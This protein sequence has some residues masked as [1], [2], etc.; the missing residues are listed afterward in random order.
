MRRRLCLCG[1]ALVLALPVPAVAQKSLPPSTPAAVENAATAGCT[2]GAFDAT[3]RPG[4]VQA[5]LYNFG[6]LFW[7]GGASTYEVPYHPA[8]GGP[9]THPLFAMGLWVSGEVGGDLR[10]AGATYSNWEFW[11]GPLD[12]NGATTSNRCSAFDRLWRVSVYDLERYTTS[13]ET[14]A[15]TQDL[16]TWPIAQGAPYFLDTNGNDRRDPSEPRLTLGP[17]D[18]GYSLNRN[19]GAVLD[20]AAGYRPDL[21][22]DEAVWWV[23]ND[24]GNVHRWSGSAPLGVEVQVLAYGYYGGISDPSDRA[25][26]LA[27]FYEYTV[28]NRGSSPIDDARVSFFVDV[29]L[30][31]YEDDQIASDPGRGMLYGY[32]GDA[33]DARSNPTYG[34]PLGYGYRVPAVGVDLLSGAA[35]AIEYRTDIAPEVPRGAGALAA[36]QNRWADG[37][38]ITRGGDGHG[39]PSGDATAWIF[40]GDP[41]TFAYWSPERPEVDGFGPLPPREV[42]GVINA[43]AATLA[44]G[45]SRRVDVAIL[46]AENDQVAPSTFRTRLHS[47]SRLRDISDAVQAAYDAGGTAAIRDAEVA[48]TAAPSPPATAPTLLGPADG[49]DVNAEAPSSLTFSWT[50]VEGADAYILDLPDRDFQT[51]GT[52]LTV[53]AADLPDGRTTT[54]WSVVP[55]NWG[56]DGPRSEIHEFSYLLYRPEALTLDDGSFAFVEVVG[57]G[58]ADPCGP[59]AQ[60]TNGCDEV[61]G[62]AI[63]GSFNST[64][65]YIGYRAGGDGPEASLPAFGPNDYEIRFTEEGSYG[66]Y[67]FSTGALIWV[68]FEVWD[69]GVVAPGA[70]NDPADDVRMIPAL[71]ADGD[72]ECVFGYSGP[73]LYGYGGTT[74]RIYAYYATTTYAEFEAAA[75]PLVDADASG[76]PTAPTTDPTEALVDADRGRPLQRFVMEQAD[77]SVPLSALSGTVLRFYTTDPLAVP[78]ERGPEAGGLGLSVWP[79]PVRG[80]ASVPFTLAAA[81]DVRLR[82]VDVLGREVA[83]LADGPRVAGEHRVALDASRLAAGVYVVV[84]DAGGQRTARTVTVVR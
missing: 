82:L 83:V 11:P 33:F 8:T 67:R 73:T 48:Y 47:V 44:P 55:V 27:T 54:R 19:Q 39:G 23:M 35:G 63:Y 50:A 52:S 32:N 18:E 74:Q 6:G 79:N 43:P 81:G 12:A 31:G 69:V 45:E 34:G 68:P 72:V 3:L 30:G 29:D 17:G 61:G 2:L 75:A 70:E 56:G 37:S 51:T 46:F 78:T 58:G 62:N 53:D 10:F 65:A 28:A 57:P 1:L 40:D 4:D 66:L 60:S 49:T 25:L 22:G 59:D 41:V 15:A 71:F 21:V 76:C 20:L 16:L 7:R 77:P 13:G 24:N 38:P 36:Q 5:K 9:G 64:G 42:S 80:A 14:G 84:L 26:G